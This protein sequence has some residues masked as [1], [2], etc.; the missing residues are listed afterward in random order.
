MPNDSELPAAFVLPNEVVSRL[1]ELAD[2]PQSSRELFGSLIAEAILFAEI[3][4]AIV[5]SNLTRPSLSHVE[6]EA[7]RI[8]KLAK[9]LD[10]TLGALE[11]KD[12][13]PLGLPRFRGEV[14]S[15]E[16]GI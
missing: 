1:A 11:E 4:H 16:E 3:N 13:D 7:R 12:P 5:R 6:R 14:R 8:T 2:V 9:D 10:R 15:W